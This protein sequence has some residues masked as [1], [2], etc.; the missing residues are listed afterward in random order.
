M[1]R[2]ATSLARYIHPQPDDLEKIVSR[3]RH[4]V[5][6]K[7][8][9]LIRGGQISQEFLFIE[10]GCLRVFWQ[11]ADREV[12]GWFAF[13]D[14][15]FCELSSF[16]PQR[17]SVYGVQA[18]EDTA[19]LVLSR[20][21]MEQLFRE[22]PVF[23]TFVRKFWEQIITHLVESI[24]SFQTE[25]AEKRYEKALQH[26]KLIQRVPLKYLSSYLGITPSSLSRLR[27]PR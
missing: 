13:E 18:L 26:P 24:I 25:T 2:L 10:T 12:T 1:Q 27:K 8:R 19:L 3:F 7:G 14:E 15:F 16:L 20:A 9:F 22:V 5:L 6:K 11:Q 23:E 4:K 17:P 21:E